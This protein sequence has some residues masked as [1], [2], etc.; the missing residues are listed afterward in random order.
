MVPSGFAEENDVLH[1]PEGKTSAE[2]T[3]LSVARGVLETGENAI[4]SCWK[5]T[6]VELS[7]ILNTGRV[8]LTVMGDTMPPVAI[9]GF[10]PFAEVPAR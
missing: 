2:V 10:R 9:S 6:A 4:V 8:W 3:P 7:E 1:P 5:P